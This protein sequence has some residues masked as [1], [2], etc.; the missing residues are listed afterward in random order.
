MG[1]PSSLISYVEGITKVALNGFTG[2]ETEQEVKILQDLMESK[3]FMAKI[4][5]VK[6]EIKGK[7]RSFLVS[8]YTQLFL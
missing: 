2:D 3:N 7:H 5:C 1:C 4:D 8:F 6:F